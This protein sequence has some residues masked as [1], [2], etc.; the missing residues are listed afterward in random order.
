MKQYPSLSPDSEEDQKEFMRFAIK[1]RIN[2]VNDFNN[3]NKVFMYGRIVGKVP[4]GA[5]DISATDRVGDTNFDFATGYMYRVV[6][7]AGTAVWARVAL[8]TVW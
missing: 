8:E 2:D 4:V 5:A 6:D 3:L 7:D 1:E